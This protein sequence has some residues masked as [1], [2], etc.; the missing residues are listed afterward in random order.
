MQGSLPLVTSEAKRVL[1]S[2]TRQSLEAR[3]VLE[4][5]TKHRLEGISTAPLVKALLQ[6]ASEE[7][8]AVPGSRH[9]KVIDDRE[10]EGLARL[11]R[12]PDSDEAVSQWES[13]RKAVRLA[14]QERRKAARV[15]HCRSVHA[16]ASGLRSTR[17]REVPSLQ[18]YSLVGLCASPFRGQAHGPCLFAQ[19]ADFL[20]R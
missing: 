17:K 16:E 14:V 7:A 4:S 2:R 9:S 1:D 11:P 6:M 8:G 5:K 18:P 12:G 13:R 10:A 15:S 20:P 3:G 19:E